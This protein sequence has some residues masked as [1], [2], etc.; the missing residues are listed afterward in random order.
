MTEETT[1]L[2][3]LV[4]AKESIKRKYIALKTGSDN[5]QQ[6]MTQTLKPIIDPLTKISNTQFTNKNNNNRET[7]N[8]ANNDTRAINNDIINYQQQI[9][10]WFQSSDID[11]IYGPKKLASGDIT[12]GNKEVKFLQNKILVDDITYPTTSGIFQLLFLKNPL[13]YT[14]N[15]LKIYKSVLIQTSAHL[16][17]NGLTIKK[18]GNKY[19]NIISKLFPSGGELFMKLQKNNLVYWDDP[20]ELVVRLRLLI[21]SKTAGNTS[22]SN[23]IISIIEEL[24]ETGLIKRIP[25]V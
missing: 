11:K 19:S 10:N 15:D 9:E 20:N 2:D 4:K 7:I 22:V 21:A 25:D 3:E 5:V 16:T 14:D 8:E 6:L 12:L 1:V 13:I 17:A 24:R 18:T 23:E